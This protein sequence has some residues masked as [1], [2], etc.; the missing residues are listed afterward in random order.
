MRY[1]ASVATTARDE[2]DAIGR[3]VQLPGLRAHY[4]DFGG[5]G[6][7][8]V[9]LHGL[10]SSSRIWSIVARALA[11]TNRVVA[12]DQRGHGLS[13][14]PDTGYDVATVAGELAAFIDELRLRRPVIVGHSWGAHVALEFAARYPEVAA[15]VVLVDGGIEALDGKSWAEVER[16]MAP[17]DLSHLT[18]AGLIAQVREW[19]WGRFWNADVEATLLSLFELAADGTVRPRLSKRNHMQILRAVWEQSLPD[20][21]AAMVA[22]VAIMPAI[23][24]PEEAVEKR[25]QVARARAL[26]RQSTVRWF[27]DSSHDIPLEHPAELAKAI[28]SFASKLDA[29]SIPDVNPRLNLAPM[30]GVGAGA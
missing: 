7:P 18:P 11:R 4:L 19:D 17:P 8:V 5:Q 3:Y 20:V 9:L 6:R 30:S 15:G 27:P 2:P 24:G 28:G 25:R 14:K 29:A 26:L 16:E 23:G 1:D 13:A 12:L 22:P 21:Y 10:A